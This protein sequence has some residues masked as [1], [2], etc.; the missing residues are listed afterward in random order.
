MTQTKFHQ[1]TTQQNANTL[2]TKQQQQQHRVEVNFKIKS[3]PQFK[4]NTKR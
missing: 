4:R 1:L 3:H 2:T